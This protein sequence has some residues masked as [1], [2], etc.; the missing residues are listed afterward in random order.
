MIWGSSF[1]ISFFLTM[2]RS[3]SGL[4]Q[5][6][7]LFSA[8][9]QI[10]LPDSSFVSLPALPQRFQKSMSENFVG[11]IALLRINIFL[12]GRLTPSK[13]VDVQKI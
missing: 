5:R 9:V 11:P 13:R 1:L 4:S 12:A 2:L 10:M 7:F 6:F 3:V 8:L